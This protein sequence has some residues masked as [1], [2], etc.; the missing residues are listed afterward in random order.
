MSVGV[1][2]LSKYNSNIAPWLK[3]NKLYAIFSNTRSTTSAKFWI[4]FYTCSSSL[5]APVAHSLAS[6]DLSF[7]FFILAVGYCVKIE[8]GKLDSVIV[9]PCAV[10]LADLTVGLD[11]L[12]ITTTTT[13]SKTG[14]EERSSSVG[15]GAI[16]VI[17]E[18]LMVDPVVSLDLEG[19][20]LCRDGTIMIIQIALR[21]GMCFLF[22]MKGCSKSSMDIALKKFLNDVLASDKYTKIIHDSRMDSDALFHQ[23]GIELTNTHDT[24]CFDTELKNLTRP[25]NL[26]DVLEDYGCDTNKSRRRN[27]YKTNPRYWATRPLTE[28]MKIYASNDV[29]LLFELYDKQIKRASSSKG[30]RCLE[31]CQLLSAK[32]LTKARDCKVKYYK[33]HP[34]QIGNFIGKR[35]SNI[36][37]LSRM[38]DVN[39]Q[40]MHKDTANQMLMVYAADDETMSRVE[41]R[42]KEY[43]KPY[44]R[45]W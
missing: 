35:G 44:H 23:F 17:M 32:N 7:F 26:N 24:Q 12:E 36:Q 4:V 9:V 22:D 14:G 19:V 45:L 10:G 37:A 3:V 5:P 21:G 1:A 15:A 27:V 28:E 43:T 13:T 39:F 42:I 20:D 16:K 40:F 8:E 2:H 25:R 30:V 33:L 11:E 34:S 31:K 29:M 6:N 38:Y 41:M 18:S